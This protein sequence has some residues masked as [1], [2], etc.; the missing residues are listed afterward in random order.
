MQGREARTE[1]LFKIHY[2]LPL[3]LTHPLAILPPFFTAQFQTMA[4][5]Y[6]NRECGRPVR[7]EE[8]AAAVQAFQARFD[9]LNRWL[10]SHPEYLSQAGLT[11]IT[12]RER[13]RHIA[14]METQGHGLSLVNFG[15]RLKP[16]HIRA[17]ARPGERSSGKG[18]KCHQ[19]TLAAI[20]IQY[21]EESNDFF[22]QAQLRMP[23]WLNRFQLEHRGNVNCVNCGEQAGTECTAC[24]CA[25]HCTSADRAR[26]RVTSDCAVHDVDLTHGC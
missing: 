15:L 16:A 14:T 18:I 4:V 1:E 20:A 25:K 7:L 12:V 22:E 23:E 2:S 10:E 19:Y 5:S 17:L 26:L 24:L 6:A 9:A 21:Y 8:I 13:W 11:L 3:C